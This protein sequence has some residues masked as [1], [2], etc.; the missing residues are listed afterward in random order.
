[1]EDDDPFEDAGLTLARQVSGYLV[2][3][4]ASLTESLVWPM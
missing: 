3:R 4:T 1:M 2:V